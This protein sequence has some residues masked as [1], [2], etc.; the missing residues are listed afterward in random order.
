MTI[1]QGTFPRGHLRREDLGALLLKDDL[2]FL[3]RLLFFAKGA[4]DI[5][6]RWLLRNRAKLPQRNLSVF[7][8]V[9]RTAD[10]GLLLGHGMRRRMLRMFGELQDLCLIRQHS[11][12]LSECGGRTKN[13]EHE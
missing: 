5:A 13:E 10:E 12:V 2:G 8:R 11:S 4:G 6:E 1:V 9:G 7:D 3:G